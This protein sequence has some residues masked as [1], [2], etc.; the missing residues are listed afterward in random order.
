MR[1][2]AGKNEVLVRESGF[3]F[4][5]FQASLSDDVWICRILCLEGKDEDEDD[6]DKASLFHP[7]ARMDQAEKRCV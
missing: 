5:V 6:F 7:D 3:S 4:F 2:Q 1:R